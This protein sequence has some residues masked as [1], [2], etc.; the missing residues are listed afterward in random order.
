MKNKELL[1]ELKAYSDS[2]RQ[3]VEAKFEGWDDSL[4]AISERRKKVLDP[5][6]GYDF[7]VSNYFPHYVRSSSRSQLHN[8]LFEHLPQVLQQ[9]SSVHLAI[10]APRGEAKSTLVS[11]LFT[12]YCLVAQKKRYALIVMDSIDQAYPMLE[13]IKVELE[14]NQRL[15]VDFPEI[16]G[17]GRVWQAATIVTKA[18]QKV[19][20]AG[21]GKKLRGLRHGAYRPDLVVLD[22]IENDE[23][24]RSPEQRDKLH[25][26]L[27]KT[28]LPLGAAGDKLDVVYIG[29]ILHYDSVL[30]RTLSSKAWKTAKFKALIRQPDDMSLWDKWEDFYLN[31]GEAVADAFYSQNKSAMDKGAVVSWAAR[32]ILTLMKI[33]ARD[34][35]AT[36]DSEYQNDPLSS[37]DAMFANA[38]TYWTELPGELVYFGALDPSLGKAGAS[39]DPS[40]ILVGGYH[41]E[42]GKLYVIEAQVKKRLPDLI[43]EDVIRMQKQYQ[44]QRWFVETVQFQEFLKD[45]LVKRSAQRGIPVPATATKPNTDKMLR[46]ESLQPH[47]ANGLILLHSSQATL[48]SQ[49]RHFPKAD[50]DDG[51]DALEMLWRNAVSS[52]AAIEWISISELDDSEWDEDESDLYSV[53]KQ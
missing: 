48:I 12:L 23:Q 47:M 30:N 33:R 42:T 44:C 5:V 15:R 10:A 14:F 17:Q 38:L 43:I 37:D 49:L 27:K 2:L 11:Q 21:S 7:F 24:V 8:Y 45:E 16:A 39:R 40:A 34:G 41:R 26:W 13:A 31:E 46:I 36:F 22:D 4:S 53:W 35:H 29:T 18:N 32:P 52:S 19:Q 20:V 3:K 51:P 1:A 25:D 9:P 28:V 50:H 6:S